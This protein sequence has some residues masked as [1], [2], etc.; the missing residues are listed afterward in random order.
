MVLIAAGFAG[1]ASS[2]QAAADVATDLAVAGEDVVS[3]DAVGD[4]APEAAPVEVAAEVPVEVVDETIAEVPCAEGA[5]KCSDDAYVLTACHDGT[6]TDVQC[7][8]GFGQLCENGKCVD[9][10]TYG[11]P[12]WSTCPTET[13]GTPETL[14]Q[15][16]TY[17]D[18]LAARL[19]FQ[20][21]VK[22][23][24]GGHLKAGA[25][26]ATATYADVDQWYTG[27]NDG[28]WSGLYLASQAF[29][30]A[31]TKSPD[32]LQNIKTL[33]DGEVDRM[34]ITG[35]PGVFTRQ[36]IPPGVPG[37]NCP[38]DVTVYIPDIE[39]DDNQWVKIQDGC[40]WVVDRDTKQW[41]K[42]DVCGLEKY[43]G[44]CWLDNVSQDEYGGHM[45]ALGAIWKLV[46]DPDVRATT[47]SLLEQ[48]AVELMQNQLAYIDWDGRVTEHGKLW[49]TSLADT[50]G[51]LSTEALD[52]FLMAIDATGRAD[53]KDFYDNCLLQKGGPKVCI[54]RGPEADSP[55]NYLDFVDQMLFFVGTD[56]CKANYN[57]FSMVFT[58]IHNLVWFAHD[59]AVREKVQAA[60]DTQFMHPTEANAQ[61]RA[62]WKQKNAWFDFGFAAHKMLGPKGN[63]PAYAEVEDG[64][65][66]MKQFPAS[67]ARTDKH[68]SANYPYYCDGRL[69]GQETETC[70]PVADRCSETFL[71]WGDPF[72]IGDVE[73]TADPA[74]LEPPG[75]YLLAYWMGRYYG[76]IPETL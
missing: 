19:H 9:P 56:G 33:L 22:W 41:T 37:L 10:W 21:S 64:I 51:F 4:V 28:L 70:I 65:C 25:T 43:N 23:A 7:M 12:T 2:N 8:T 47:K 11:S 55:L 40:D 63:G 74:S 48:V 46:D 27:E 17:Y 34:A 24:L 49:I 76:F 53:L 57:N 54:N 59:P 26:E 32:A 75:D 13:H 35:R 36:L 50:P 3:P 68:L 42:T 60:W 58:W 16:A 5:W 62:G 73:C 67:K 31:V 69:N 45:L 39:K 6:W 15:K 38:T 1:C 71:W 18:A 66:S 14:A 52:M 72:D 20:P 30:Y 44:Y 61:K 29:R